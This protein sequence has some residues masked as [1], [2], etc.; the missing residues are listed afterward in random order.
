MRSPG[1]IN[2]PAEQRADLA[3]AP[4]DKGHITR[5]G[6]VRVAGAKVTY[7]TVGRGPAMVFPP[8]LLARLGLE[9]YSEAERTFYEILADHFT[10]VRYDRWG[11]GQSD[12]QRPLETVTLDTEVATVE[13]LADELD[14]TSFDLFGSSY[15]GCIAAAYAVQHPG[16]VR[17]LLLF[18]SYANGAAIA[19][20]E[21]REAII[22]AVRADWGLG[23]QILTSVVVP[24]DDRKVAQAFLRFHRET[25]DSGL[26]SAFLELCYRTDLRDQLGLINT[27]TLVLHRRDD[28][29]SRLALGREL[30]ALIPGSH[31]E[32]LEGRGHQPWLD[33]SEAVLRAMG[34]FLGVS[35]SISRRP[36]L[37]GTRP[38]ANAILSSRETEVLRL[39]ADG[40]SDAEIADRLF[41]S[42][43]TVHRHVANIRARLGQSSRAAAA[44]WATRLSLI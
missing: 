5:T 39:V 3:F 36:L 17:R 25:V 10:V 35:L 4:S 11:T 2:V 16:R 24:G 44:A 6:F 13:A 21:V 37:T 42:R 1:L 40:L 15:G 31:L 26:A 19:P 34:N 28:Q 41:L 27:P 12:R 23:S 30:S 32:V 22:G 20:P 29:V 43:H 7:A 38:Q 8:A 14:L 33:D 18:G 9:A